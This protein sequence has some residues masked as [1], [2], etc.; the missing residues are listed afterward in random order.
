MAHPYTTR[1]LVRQAAINP[2]R[3][4]HLLDHNGDGVEDAVDG[5][6]AIAT[7]IA[8]ACTMIDAHLGRRYV[9]PFASL[10]DTPSL[11]Q[12]VAS[13]LVIGELYERVEPDGA[14]AKSWRGKALLVLNRLAEKT[15]H[16]DATEVAATTRRRVVYESA[17][18]F[19]A[20]RV[21]DDYTDSGTDKSNGI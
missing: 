10:T 7:A 15:M 14:D 20:G 5:T 13:W 18:T 11:I 1:A 17:G 12:Q 2:E 3:I 9:T 8:E 21:D 6:A 4:A 19:V 16:L